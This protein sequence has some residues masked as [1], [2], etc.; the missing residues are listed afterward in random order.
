MKFMS[1][2]ERV[3]RS[4]LKDCFESNELLIFIVQPGQIGKAIGKSASNI[5]KLEQMFNRK[6]KIVEFNP[7]K[8]QFIK[9]IIYPLKIKEI[10]DIEG[11]V[12]LTS[13]DS[14]TR[15]ILIGRNAQNL[16]GTE[17]IVKRF[18]EI[19]EIKVV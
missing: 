14:K 19:Q 9:N 10:E 15:G 16:R 5:K 2:F 17:S 11:I 3:T 7:Q 6:I 13:G 8:I 1:M 12:T 18:F 4:N